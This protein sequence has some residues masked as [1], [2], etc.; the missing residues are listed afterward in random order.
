MAAPRGSVPTDT[1]TL[2]VPSP[3][4]SPCPCPHP[5]H[6][7]WR[8]ER[9]AKALSPINVNLLEFSRLQKRG[10]RRQHRGRAGWAQGAPGCPS[11]GAGDVQEL[12]RGDVGEGCL[13]DLR[14]GRVHHRPAGETKLQGYVGE[15]MVAGGLCHPRTPQHHP[16]R[17][18]VRASA[19]PP[20]QPRDAGQGAAHGRAVP[21]AILPAGGETEGTG[22]WDPQQGLAPTPLVP[23]PCGTPR[24]EYVCTHRRTAPRTLAFLSEAPVSPRD[25][26]SGPASRVPLGLWSP[27]SQQTGS[28]A[29]TGCSPAPSITDGWLPGQ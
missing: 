12:Q 29:G 23:T 19:A 11:A 1:P 28:A 16:C 3:E 21:A 8:C 27:R 2:P 9:P 26:A 7:Y 24:P 13:S 17:H 10:R 5:T 18:P 6:R 25:R 4:S 22:C 20:P 15:G 14:E